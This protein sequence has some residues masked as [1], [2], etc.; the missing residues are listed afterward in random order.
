[1]QMSDRRQ[2]RS[3]RSIKRLA[4]ETSSA[5]L[6]DDLAKTVGEL[7]AAESAAQHFGKQD[8]DAREMLNPESWSKE[9]SSNVRGVCS[10]KGII[11]HGMNSLLA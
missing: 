2:A 3:E 4:P 8:C 9:A 7:G 1:M 6:T 10:A 5:A 11:A